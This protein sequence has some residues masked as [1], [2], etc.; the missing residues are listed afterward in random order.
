LDIHIINP[1]SI[2]A[3][4]VIDP[5]DP[6]SIILK[7]A[8]EMCPHLVFQEGLAVC[9]IHHMPCYQGTPCQQF[10]QIGPNDAVCSMS[11]Y[12]K[13]IDHQK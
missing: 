1:R 9:T 11:S 8:G 12:F 2:L 4:G 3:G 13:A 5:E 10:E 6:M 7:S